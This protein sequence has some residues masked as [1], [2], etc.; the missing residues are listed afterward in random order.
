M[1]NEVISNTNSITL[2]WADKG[3]SL[4]HLQVS[5]TYM[6]FRS[7]L[8]VDDNALAS[9]TKSFTATGNGKYFWRYKVKIGAT[10][11]DW[12]E[13]FSFIVNTSASADVSATGWTMINKSDISDLYLIENQPVNQPIVEH[14]HYWEAVRRN[15]AGKLRSEHFRTKD[16]ITMDLTRSGGFVGANEKAEVLRFY[17]AHTSFYLITKY[18]NQTLNDFVYRV[19]EVL[20]IETPQMDI[21]GGNTVVMEEV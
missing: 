20:I 5:K 10:W 3:G 18:D 21:P 9:S 2:D 7:T 19:W 15:R 11:G 13:V 14:I 1:A 8:I 17:N 6:D 16:R 12:S 4:W